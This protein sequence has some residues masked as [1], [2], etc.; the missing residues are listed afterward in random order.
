MSGAPGH[1]AGHDEGEQRPKVLLV[2]DDEV[3]LMLVAAALTQHGFDVTEVDNGDQALRVLGGWIPDLVVLDARM[4]GLDGFGL[5]AAL[6]QSARPVPV[7]LFTA[8]YEDSLRAKALAGGALAFLT[9]PVS[10]SALLDVVQL[11]LAKSC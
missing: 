4:P 11:A 7:V 10:S 3:N 9:K 2:D 5:L 1:A 8:F 6:Q